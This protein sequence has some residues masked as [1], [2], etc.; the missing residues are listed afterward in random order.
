MKGRCADTSPRRTAPLSFRRPGQ[1][2]AGAPVTTTT[3]SL[4]SPT[5]TREN[6]RDVW[7]LPVILGLATF[8]YS[9]LRD[10]ADSDIATGQSPRDGR[11]VA[12]AAP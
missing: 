1:A 4:G 5:K 3:A 9:G 6:G 10:M 11:T 8:A 2:V 7:P 12:P